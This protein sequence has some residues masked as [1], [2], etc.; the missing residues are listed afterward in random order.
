[1]W[2]YPE[3][4]P[5]QFQSDGY[6][7]GVA[8]THVLPGHESFSTTNTTPLILAAVGSPIQIAGYAKLALANGYAGKF[9]YLGQYFDKAY[10]ANPD[11]T[12]STNETGFLSPYGQFFPTEPGPTILTTL[13][14]GVSTNVGECT[15]HVIGLSVDANHDGAL[16]LA[17]TGPDQTSPEHPMVFWANN[18]YDRGHEVDCLPVCDWE[19]DDLLSAG[20]PARPNTPTPDCDFQEIPGYYSIPSARDL[21]DYTRL[22]IPG[23]AAL[24]EAH[25][26]LTF[27]LTIVSDGTMG[28]PAI[29]L[30]PA[31]ETNGAALYLTDTNAA[32]AQVSASV[33][34]LAR[35]E[36]DQPVL[37]NDMFLPSGQPSD[38]FI[39]CGA[40]RGSGQLVLT[41][42]DGAE[43][44]AETS[45]YL[46][47]N[48][49]K[50]LYERWTLGDIPSMEPTDTAFLAADELPVVGALPFLYPLP[51]SS[52]T[53]YILHVH[54]WNMQP[55]IKDRFA[56]TAFKR[57]YWQGYQGRFG[58]FRW[59]TDYDF[60]SVWD[61]LFDPQNYDRSELH[62]WKSGE[63]LRNLL[64]T[65][66]TNYPGQVRLM[67]HSMGGIVAGQAL[68]V[69]GANPDFVHT[70][71]AMQTAVPSHS[72]D[73]SIT[74]RSLGLSD[75][76]TPNRYARYWNTNSPQYFVNVGG[77]SRYI[78][79]FNRDDY[80][81]EK[82]ELNQDL[83]PD[84]GYSYDVCCG[85]DAD[86]GLFRR[87]S[88]ELLW[89][90]DAFELFSF[91]VEAR[92]YA[93]G[94]QTGLGGAF[95]TDGQID[96]RLSPFQFGEA[97]IGH[98]AQFRS[99][100]MQRWS[101]W[102]ELLFATDLKARQ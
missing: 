20:C 79:L 42:L 44:V 21:E 75:S 76:G 93:V 35:V 24:Y 56:E 32:N 82:W 87:G 7:F 100:N 94:A 70:Y 31:V 39:L 77:A 17:Y 14:D 84:S 28:N 4:E 68:R 38:H 6:Y 64:M 43:V 11:G 19:E 73:P 63:G 85:S 26:N 36:S 41:V 92:C 60:N 10:K 98:S 89:P 95:T 61:V 101:I 74:N 49:I 3:V 102:E 59:P 81:L 2:F 69:S 72:Y 33:S 80:A 53:P 45:L 1:V 57:L 66:N 46:Q 29:N 5:P 48:D 34:Y 88:T 13:P 15:V 8:G 50:E 97:H 54:G 52:N 91:C 90:A 16:D 51:A 40:R 55:W 78:N 71:V 96:L 86:G 23:L 47:F 67:A 12:R 37:L 62:A 18:D 22:W 9:A 27:R 99:T 25:S 30:F 58:S 83:K 65:L